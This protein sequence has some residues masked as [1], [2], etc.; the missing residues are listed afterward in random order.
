MTSITQKDI[1]D[2]TNGAC[3]LLAE[4]VMKETGWP[5]AAFWNGFR[6]C[7]HVF[8]VLPDG[9]YLDIEGPRTRQELLA[10][11]GKGR[12]AITTRHVQLD[13]WRLPMW[14]CT[15]PA[16]YTARA[17]KIIPVLLATVNA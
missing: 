8:N 10:R 13:E 3:F 7:G 16:R 12:R 5:V 2:F 15:S 14:N 6:P 9:R 17:K 11:R 4:A 1:H